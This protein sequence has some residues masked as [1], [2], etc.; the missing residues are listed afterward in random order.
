MR[1][2]SPWLWIPC[3]A[4]LA[5]MGAAA[6]LAQSAGDELAFE[7]ALPPPPGE[8]PVAFKGDR[9]MV[10]HAEDGFETKLV[11][12]AP[13]QAEAV[14]EVVQTLADGNR[15]V[16]KTTA[17][18]YRDGEGRTRRE[19]H[20]AA[21]GPLVG[22]EASRSVFLSDPV[23]G[24]RHHL[25]LDER[26]AY[27]LPAAPRFESAERPAHGPHDRFFFTKRIGPQGKAVSERHSAGKPESL[28]TQ[29]VEGVEARGTRTRTVIA[30]G[31]IG[32]ERSIEIVSERWY[33][34]E[35]QVVVSSR[36]SDPRLGETTYRL[37]NISR[38]E[39]DRALFEVPAD[40]KVSD[41]PPHKRLR[42][43]GKEERPE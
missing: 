36:H 41:E 18:V 34:P 8:D 27:K 15:I 1:L 19:G 6:A 16:R 11:K 24:T 33:S 22:S 29:V 39:P 17:A 23:A 42:H 25:D 14:T 12:A 20:L 3:C 43:G 31:E 28:G 2:P 9:I 32:N 37:Q 38:G 5:P 40:F 4:A 30:A 7:L 13:Y 21:I 10:L 35:L 26:V